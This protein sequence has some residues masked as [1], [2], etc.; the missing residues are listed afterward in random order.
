MDTALAIIQGSKS[1][2]NPTSLCLTQ[3]QY[4]FCKLCFIHFTRGCIK[5]ILADV[6]KFAHESAIKY[7]CIIKIIDFVCK[8]QL[9]YAIFRFGVI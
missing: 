2:D 1:L 7:L 4:N 3:L 6:L 9:K 8:T 5:V